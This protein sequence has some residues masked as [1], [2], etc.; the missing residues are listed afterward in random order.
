MVVIDD[1]SLDLVVLYLNSV[2]CP[3]LHF[4]FTY[5]R[6]LTC[7]KLDWLFALPTKVTKCLPSWGPQCQTTSLPMEPVSF[8]LIE[9][10]GQV[11]GTAL[12]SSYETLLFP[13]VTERSGWWWQGALAEGSRTCS[14]E[15]GRQSSLRKP[16]Q[17]FPPGHSRPGISLLNY[18]S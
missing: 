12:E 8:S 4:P 7:Y 11:Q 6:D 16:H 2:W 9:P 5:C 14:E 18:S 17:S 1:C 3:W 10:W 15:Q 13:V